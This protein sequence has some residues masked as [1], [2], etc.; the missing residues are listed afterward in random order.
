M[1]RRLT[2]V[3]L[4][5]ADFGI[6]AVS[7]YL[8]CQDPRFRFVNGAGGDLHWQSIAAY[9]NSRRQ[10]VGGFAL[11]LPIAGVT[12]SRVLLFMA[13]VLVFFDDPVMVSVP[14]I[15]RHGDRARYR[16]SVRRQSP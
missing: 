16:L 14:V 3:L 8:P 2:L 1:V 15:L 5:C 10:G 6:V 11:L 4:F 12:G 7:D 9:E 13:A